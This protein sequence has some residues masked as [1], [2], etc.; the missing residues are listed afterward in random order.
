M[1]AKR[2]SMRKTKEILRLHHG[3]GLSARK[4]ASSQGVARSTVGE[5]LRRAKVA[6]ISW[7][8]PDGMDEEAL[9]KLLY[10]PKADAQLD[11]PRPDWNEVHMEMRRHKHLT[12]QLLWFEYRQKHPDGYSY[13]RFCGQ[14]RA[15]KRTIELVMRQE[16]KAG[17]KTFIDFAG[18]GIDITDPHTGEVN[19]AELFVAVLGASNYTFAW[20]CRDQSLPSWVDAHERM[21]DYFGGSTQVLVPDNL[22]S[23]VI[24]ADRYEPGIN[25][26]Y[27]DLAEHFSAVVI[28]A[29]KGKARDKAKVESGVLMA[30]RWILAALRNHTFFSIGEANFAVREKLEEL[31]TKP[32]QKLDGNRRTHYLQVDK[33]ALQ[34]LPAHRFEYHEWKQVRVNV[35]YHVEVE[36]HYYSVPH[37]LVHERLWACVTA[38]TVELLRNGRRVACH[39]RSY[40]KGKHTT[41]EEHMPKAH[42][43]HAKWKPS[44]IINWASNNGPATGELVKRLIET[45]RHPQW[46]YRPSLGII[47][48]GDSYGTERLEAACKRA[49][50]MGTVSYQSVKSI[51]KTGQDRMPLRSERLE[52]LT[53]SEHENV[54]GPD[55]YS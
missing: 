2:L 29:R 4:I 14:Y 30:E 32:F 13:S 25:R 1:G 40:R 48:L 11:R 49:L 55:Y 12:L 34:P 26:T 50:Y 17:E 31:N 8:L 35:D 7:P 53:P 15:W 38:R 9:D 39:Q 36:G 3:L 42:R 51:L 52:R 47:R 46:G 20:V 21:F 41:L 19:K 24:K 33:P 23:G 28:P 37:G 27:E 16:H 10:P 44:R 6:G 54:R 5:V 45:K 43:E 18:D 22:K